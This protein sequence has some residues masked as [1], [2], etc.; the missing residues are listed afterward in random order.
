[1]AGVVTQFAG[2]VPVRHMSLDD[3]GRPIAAHGAVNIDRAAAGG[4]RKGAPMAGRQRS[5]AARSASTVELN[6]TS[7][8]A[9]ARAS[10]DGASVT[11]SAG[12]FAGLQDLASMQ[13]DRSVT[14]ARDNLVSGAVRDGRIAASTAAGYRERWDSNVDGR[15]ALRAELEALPKGAHTPAAAA[16]P[17]SA[18]SAPSAA[19]RA[20]GG[21]LKRGDDGVLRYGEFAATLNDAGDPC[22]FTQDGWMTVAAFER[23]GLET[24][25]LKFGALSA[26]LGGSASKSY[27]EGPR[28]AR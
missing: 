19:P 17:A 13:I 23:A 6:R 2:G 4:S 20:A 26:S 16:A 8:T 3:F 9:S 15:P 11:L 12:E 22:V 7:L 24:E 28:S 1:M 25:E 10:A 18:T 21:Q 5:S 14:I 27:R